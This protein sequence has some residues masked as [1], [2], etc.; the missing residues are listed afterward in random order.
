MCA[1]VGYVYAGILTH[2]GEVLHG[3]CRWL[4]KKLRK[5]H[6]V[7]GTGVAKEVEIIKDH[8]LLKPL[9]ACEKCVAGQLALWSYLV[10]NFNYR[11]GQ[12]VFCVCLAI[13]LTVIIKKGIDKL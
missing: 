12:H 1:V 5:T 10:S 11:F 8:W 13:L 4:H 7:P 2:P 3:W 6:L 9:V